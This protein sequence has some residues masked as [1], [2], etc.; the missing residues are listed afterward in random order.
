MVLLETLYYVPRQPKGPLLAGDPGRGPG[1]VA[2][3]RS[4]PISGDDFSVPAEESEWPFENG[5]TLSYEIDS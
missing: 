1:K 2:S 4:E 5:F 3:R